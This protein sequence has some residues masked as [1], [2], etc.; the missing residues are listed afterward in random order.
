MS[1]PLGIFVVIG[2]ALGVE[3]YALMNKKPGDTISEVTWKVIR[4]NPF[5]PFLVGFLMGHLF[6][7]PAGYLDLLK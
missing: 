6:W 3:V 2:I 5:I 7:P 4:H 1:T